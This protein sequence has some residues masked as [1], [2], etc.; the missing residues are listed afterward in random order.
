MPSLRK[1]LFALA[2]LAAL[3]ACTSRLQSTLVPQTLG[4]KTP[5]IAP[6]DETPPPCPTCDSGGGLPNR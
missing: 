6:M 2:A 3:S 5:T 4:A 1:A